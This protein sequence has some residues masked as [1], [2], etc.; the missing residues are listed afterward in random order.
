MY[1]QILQRAGAVLVL[2]GL[3]DIAVMIYCI[4]NGISYSSSFN[5]FA[6]VAGVFLI[7]GSLRAASIVRWFAVFM[8]STFVS[9]LL[10]WP[11]LQPLGLTLTQIKFHPIPSAVT[12]ALMAGILALLFW[13]AKV[14]GSEPVQAAR[15]EQ[16]RKLR[17]MWIPAGIGVGMVAVLGISLT[18]LLGGESAEHATSIARQQVG[19]G[20]Q[21]YVGTLNVVHTQQ[22]KFVSGIVTAWNDSEI[23]Y[24][25]VR[26][27]E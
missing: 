9:L 15:A 7:R 12:A 22:G 4:A 3:V 14:L 25:P 27:D 17:K 19:E 10:A 8:L 18:L 21:F 5:I 11:L 24:V 16:G 13:L 26:W 23:R 20:Y 6:V 2:V 1:T